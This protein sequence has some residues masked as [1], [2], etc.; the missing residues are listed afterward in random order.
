[1]DIR[2]LSLEDEDDEQIV[3]AGFSIMNLT[4]TVKERWKR[5]SRM[6]KDKKK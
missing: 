6:I 5:K 2:S 4:P 3:L 1:M